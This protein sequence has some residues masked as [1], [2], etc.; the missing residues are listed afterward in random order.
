MRGYA[1]VGVVA[2]EF[3]V[4]YVQPSG[5][6]HVNGVVPDLFNNQ[7]ARERQKVT[8]VLGEIREG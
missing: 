2:Q 5:G 1:P 6:P 8:E 3:N 4:E 7:D